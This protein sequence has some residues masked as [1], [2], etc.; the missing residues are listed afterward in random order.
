ML[1]FADRLF[2]RGRFEAGI[3]YLKRYARFLEPQPL[4]PAVLAN[5]GSRCASMSRDADAAELFRWTLGLDPNHITALTGLA[6]LLTE[7]L[8]LQDLDQALKLAQKAAD[9]TR[10]KNP[11]VLLTLALCH[12]ERREFDRARETAE[13]ALALPATASDPTLQ[14]QIRALIGNLNEPSL[15]P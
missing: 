9:Q 12:R 11:G 3:D 14:T 13:L 6:K 4:F 10:S 8:A 2:Q 5:A 15:S 7:N 1:N